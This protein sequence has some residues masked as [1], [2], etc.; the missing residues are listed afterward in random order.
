MDFNIGKR[1]FKINQV[2]V[3]DDKS[4]LRFWGKADAESGRWHPLAYH[5]LDVAAV[6][7]VWLEKNEKLF[8]LFHKLSG[9]SE[10]SL[11]PLLTLSTAF[12]DLGK[13]TVHFQNKIPELA[14][15]NDLFL[16]IAAEE[17]GFDHGKFG[18]LWID[19]W[20]ENDN[21]FQ[22]WTSKY[23]FIQDEA[24]LK[25]WKSACWHHGQAY[26]PTDYYQ[27]QPVDSKPSGKGNIFDK[28]FLFRSELL[29]N[30]CEVVLSD[31]QMIL[32]NGISI[33]PS[34]ARLYA[35]FVSVC[36]WLG[37]NKENFPYIG[38]IE[39][40]KLKEYWKSI[41][42]KA[43]NALY[44][45]NLI[46]NEKIKPIQ[47]IAD[48]LGQNRQPRPVQIALEKSFI[49][50]TSLLIVEAPTGEG[51][52]ESALFQ[53]ARNH[54]RGFYFGLPTQASANQIS[55][56]I[57]NFIKNI[58]KIKEPAI[59]AHGNSWL[60][61]AMN[62][63]KKY[64]L[65]KNNAADI[66]AETELS[67]WF[68]SKKRTLLSHY[69]VG[70]VDQAMLSALNVKHG[71]VKL[72]G[73]AG[74]TLIIDEVH[75]Y[76]SFMLPILEHLIRWCGFL[77]TSVVLLSATLPS[78]M[79]AKL[80]S[81]YLNKDE[82]ES[83]ATKNSYPLL[84]IVNKNSA[85][86][87]KTHEI[88]SL[89]GTYIKTRKEESIKIVFETHLKD[90]VSNIIEILINKLKG[91]GNI[92]WICNT[93][94][95]AQF[96][97]SILS[98]EKRFKDTK[99][100][101]FHSRFTKSDRLYIEKKVEALY[102][103]E[104]K[105]S[106]RPN[107][108]ILVAT[109]VA[110]QSLDIDFDYLVTDIAPIDLILQRAGR[111]FRHERSNRNSNFTKP[112]ILILLPNETT[113]IKDFAG[114]YDTFT[115][116]KTIVELSIVLDQTIQLPK[117]YRTMVENVYND[118]IPETRCVNCNNIL[119]KIDNI[120]WPK[121]LSKKIEKEQ[122]LEFKGR[123]N[124]IP[125]PTNEY[126]IDAALLSEEDNSYWTA[127]TRD[128]QESLGLILVYNMQNQFFAGDKELTLKIPD[129]I[130]ADM[131][132]QM[133]LNTVEISS[134]GFVSLAKNQNTLQKDNELATSWQNK[135]DKTP[136]LKGK[137]ILILDENKEASISFSKAEFKLSYSPIT[138]LT[139]TKLNLEQGKL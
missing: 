67:E 73:L 63:E 30:I 139:L 45:A 16:Q 92:L 9:I 40:I 106:V 13:A 89:D 85:E 47:K 12:H 46:T 98:K 103:D 60:I 14:K 17:K 20:R 29:R 52:T 93:I 4:Y 115:V 105:S 99:I 91:G 6:A 81:A 36:D 83:N 107:Q 61:K 25:L 86:Y 54:G 90:N 50:S 5:M 127:K 22:N 138:G 43:N 51:K 1:G 78:K 44:Q 41:Q 136:V 23:Q 88:D 109:Q 48:I 26:V 80:I 11:I 59:L 55:G 37:S 28:V 117:M 94:N 116:L 120:T 24:F 35:G 126:P 68:N 133:S 87:D 64:Q 70:T 71:F 108:S 111:I 27:M 77:N 102:G 119:L 97:Y 112:E 53:F 65:N 79:K 7:R 2:M 42:G 34:F 124:L 19:E 66:C 101:L 69:G 57:E 21:D 49:S 95:K 137:K 135:M 130:E 75:A 31:F 96:V 128:G 129:K 118:N 33:S 110:E 76:D 3:T 84:T 32:Q 125:M 74:K 122:E 132:I 131:L 56:R 121:A 62:E 113:Q 134:K 38:Y 104:E 15:K 39:E 82:T 10:K 58:L 18:C 114:V 8:E 72:F 123:Q 100:R